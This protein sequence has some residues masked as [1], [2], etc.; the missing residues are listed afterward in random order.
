MGKEIQM[1]FDVKEYDMR[2]WKS[3]VVETTGGMNNV[4]ESFASFP[5][6]YYV[7]N[8][9]RMVFDIIWD[10]WK[11]ISNDVQ[12]FA[13]T[14][15]PGMG[16]SAF[17]V[18]LEFFLTRHCSRN[19]LLLRKVKTVKR[20]YECV[21]LCKD[22]YREITVFRLSEMVHIRTQLQDEYP[23]LLFFADSFTDVD[24]QRNHEDLLPY[25]LLAT[26]SQFVPK[27]DDPTQQI[28][29]PTWQFD[30]LSDF[31]VKTKMF[32]KG[33]TTKEIYYY[34]GGS[35]REFRK[36]LEDLKRTVEQDLALVVENNQ[37]IMLMGIYG[38]AHSGQVNRI[39]RTYVDN[40]ENPETYKGIGTLLVDSR[41]VLQRLFQRCD[42]DQYEKLYTASKVVGGAFH[43]V[44]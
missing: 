34:S 21:L 4:M 28:L 16:K 20:G 32:K 9:V 26:S 12:K 22:Y 30:A 33:E 25:A 3:G 37:A 38:G 23:S 19:I 2:D 35:L 7:Q 1:G 41:Y 18:Y 24:V 17:M 14:G 10:S 44:S 36:N 11:E 8:E 39:R 31:A 5:S 13:I 43:A 40:P 15:S 27:N 6:Q 29:L 42:V